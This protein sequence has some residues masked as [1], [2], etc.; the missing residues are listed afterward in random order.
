ML[1][2]TREVSVKHFGEIWV[3]QYEALL[4][5]RAPFSGSLV[6]VPGYG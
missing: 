6:G 2:A 3:C 1:V 4:L 5:P